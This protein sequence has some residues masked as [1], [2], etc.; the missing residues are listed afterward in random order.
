MDIPAEAERLESAAAR[1]A[2]Q[3]G[4]ITGDR[5]S[6]V[7]PC[8]LACTANDHGITSAR[9]RLQPFTE[10]LETCILII[11]AEVLRRGQPWLLDLCAISVAAWRYGSLKFC[12]QLDLKKVGWQYTFCLLYPSTRHNGDM[13]EP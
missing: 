12:Y 1:T 10:I 7:V 13:L 5:V 9:D 8:W 3:V 2:H 6:N 11:S 4:G